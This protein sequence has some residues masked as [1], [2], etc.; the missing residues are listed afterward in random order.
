[1]WYFL[2]CRE[3]NLE[4]FRVL[5]QYLRFFLTRFDSIETDFGWFLRSS[6]N[7][8]KIAVLMYFRHLI[9]IDLVKPSIRLFLFEF[10]ELESINLNCLYLV[11]ILFFPWW[12]RL[13]SS[14]CCSR[15][16]FGRSCRFRCWVLTGCRH[17]LLNRRKLTR[18]ESFSFSVLYFLGLK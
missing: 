17:R 12:V 5:F 3:S 2:I 15:F 4:F 9:S 13:R 6:Y 11:L 14:C 8:L 7:Y 18:I 16:R 10:F 1:M